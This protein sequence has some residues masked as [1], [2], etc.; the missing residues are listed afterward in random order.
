MLFNY[1]I[2]SCCTK[3]QEDRSTSAVFH[4]LKGKRSI[5]TV[6]DA[7]IYELNHFYG[8]YPTLSKHDFEVHVQQ[9]IKNNDL[10]LKGDNTAIVTR[11]GENWINQEAINV[12]GCYFHGMEYSRYAP[13]FWQ[14]LLLMIQTM[15]NSKRHHFNFIPVIDKTEITDWVRKQY[16]LWKYDTS[17][18]LNKLYSELFHLLNQFDTTE[19]S[20]FVDSLTGY[21]HYGMSSF[22]IAERYGLEQVDVP[23]IRTS[24]IH[25]M[26]MLISQNEQHTPLLKHF[27]QDLTH[28]AKVTNSA[29]KTKQFM[30]KG[31]SAENIASIRQLKLNTIYDHMVEIALYDKAFPLG[32]YVTPDIQ[33]QIRAAIAAADSYKLKDI[34]QHVSASISYFQIRLVLATDKITW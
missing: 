18:F 32:H 21:N 24:T 9:L 23:L 20:I 3:F 26:L 6:Q 5:Q 19:A 13:V 16:R 22:Q 31:Y 7:H 25:R 11:K 2:L 29:N 4:L 27:L 1:I 28:E 33:A 8:I 34:K 15:T 17:L 10:A 12:S 30:A 14:R